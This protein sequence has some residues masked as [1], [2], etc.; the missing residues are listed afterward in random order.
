M[1]G[2]TKSN[3]MPPGR[4]DTELADEFADFFLDKIRRIRDDLA[5]C[6]TYTPIEIEVEPLENFNPLSVGEVVSIIRSMPTKSCE[7]DVLPTSLLKRSLDRLG[8]T[9]TAI[10]NISL[11]E[12]IFADKWKVAIVRPLL[13]KAGLDLV[14]ANYRPVS[15]L[16]FLSKVNEKCMLKHFNR[17]CEMNNLL[18]EYQSA[19]R[20]HYS[21]ETALVKIAD[22]ILWSMEHQRITAVV[23]IDLSA[24]FDT[25]DHDILLK[26]LDTRFG[27]RGTA[28]KWVESYLRPRSV[29]VNCGSAYSI[30]HP[31]EFSVPQGSWGRAG[32]LFCI[33]EHD[34]GYCPDHHR[35]TW[36]CR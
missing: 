19:Y 17:H 23:A 26:V 8:K 20:Q 4:K 21:C 12:G 35:D 33:C 34:E 28:N 24:A 14:A 1:T 7:S 2:R 31:I 9:I 27:I 11:Q 3:P 29:K 18:P 10:V 6:R 13:K 22:D 30:T 16:P 36:I 5:D 15:N 32:V 25:V